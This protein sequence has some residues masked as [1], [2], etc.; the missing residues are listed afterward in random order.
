MQSSRRRRRS[1]AGLVA[2][3]GVGAIT[4][5]AVTSAQ[6][7]TPLGVQAR[8]SF[9][10]ADGD[11]ALTAT[12]PSVA[13]NPVANQYLIVWSREDAEGGEIF[14]RLVD[15]A[16]APVGAEFRVSDMGAATLAGFDAVEPAITYNVTRNEYLVVWK[17]DD[18]RGSLVDDE[19]EI[20]AQI[21]RAHV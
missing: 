19:F 5:G 2:V 3:L 17:G 12:S 1:R 4:L 18:D 8:I 15:A 7:T 13:Y 14:G 20:F 21:G 6:A 16:G 9:T 10:G 11:G